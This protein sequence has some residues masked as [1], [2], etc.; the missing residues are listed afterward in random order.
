MNV[1]FSLV[2]D[3]INVVLNELSVMNS[4]CFMYRMTRESTM[5]Y[6]QTSNLEADGRHYTCRKIHIDLQ[7]WDG[8]TR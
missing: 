2:K 6:Q 4:V 7:K 3:Q 1:V 8:E 5:A